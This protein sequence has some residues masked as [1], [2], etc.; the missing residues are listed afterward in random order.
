M[1]LPFLLRALCTTVFYPSIDF[2]LAPADNA[3]ADF[4]LLREHALAHQVVDGAV[5]Q[6]G[7]FDHR[8]LAN[9]LERGSL[10]VQNFDGGLHSP[11]VQWDQYVTDGFSRD[12]ALGSRAG[13]S[14]ASEDVKKP[15]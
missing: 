6:A 9:D 11:F 8:A 4:D 13:F 7:F 12:R 2:D 10:R 14:G 3:R 5:S 1:V 15:V